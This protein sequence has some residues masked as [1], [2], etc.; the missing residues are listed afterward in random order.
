MA[1]QEIKH[2]VRIARTDLDG[3]KP[4]QHAMLKIKGVGFTFA[5]MVCSF[6]GIDKKIKAGYLSEEQI[7]KLTDIIENPLKHGAP[8]WM[9]NRRRDYETNE[10]KHLLGADITFHQ[11]NDIKRQKKIK[12]YVGFRHAHGQPVRGQRTRSNFRRNKGNVHLGVQRKKEAPA[13]E[14]SDDKKK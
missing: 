3:H 7:L 8:I 11:D 1:E 9:I 6:S 13:A 10:N 5:N 4:V 14:K 12:S 2:L